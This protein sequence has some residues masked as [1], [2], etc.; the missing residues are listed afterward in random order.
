[1]AFQVLLII[2][3]IELAIIAG[4]MFV[5]TP[6]NIKSSKTE[7]Y[8]WPYEIPP[9]NYFESPESQ[10]LGMWYDPVVAS[11]T[12]VMTTWGLSQDLPPSHA[13]NI[14][15]VFGPDNKLIRYNVENL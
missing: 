8:S 1:M 3:L 7:R 11:D 15:D 6:Q 10:N 2:L 9:L 14:D 12:G 5:N 4:L 13:T